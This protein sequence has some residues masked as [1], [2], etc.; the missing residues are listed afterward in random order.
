GGR[1]RLCRLRTA[2]R[3]ASGRVGV[4]AAPVVAGA[5]VRARQV[6]LEE[7]PRGAGLLLAAEG[8]EGRPA[9][10]AGPVVASPG[11]QGRRLPDHQCPGGASLAPEN[12]RQIL[13]L[14]V[15]K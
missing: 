15:E 12:G 5:V 9:A 13:P 2:E 1:R 14:E 6:H 7:V 4:L 3:P 10:V 8:A 11:R